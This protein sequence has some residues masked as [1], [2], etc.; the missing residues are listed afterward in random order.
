MRKQ[1]AEIEAFGVMGGQQTNSILNS[2][3]QQKSIM[4]YFG[5]M[6]MN[7]IQNFDQ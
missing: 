6:S 2:G 1:L 3:G 4:D 7:Q 5:S